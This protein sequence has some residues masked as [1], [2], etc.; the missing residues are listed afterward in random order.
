MAIIMGELF[1]F[2]IDVTLFRNGNFENERMGALE[3]TDLSKVPDDVLIRL[4]Q[5]SQALKLSKLS[6][7]ELIGL[8]NE[9]RAR[10]APAESGDELIASRAGDTRAKMRTEDISTAYDFAQARA[11]ETKAKIGDGGRGVAD[12]IAPGRRSEEQVSYDNARAEQKAMAEAYVQR[13]RADNPSM[14]ITDRTRTIGRGVPLAGPAGDEVNAFL[15]APLS[16]MGLSDSGQAYE[17]VLDYTRARNR[18]FDK[19]HPMESLGLQVGGGVTAGILAGPSILGGLSNLSR[20]AAVVTGAGLGSVTG[21]LDAFLNGEG[22]AAE[23]LQ[24]VPLGAG[25]GGLIGGAAPVAAEVIA[26]GVGRVVSHGAVRKALDGVGITRP[27][28]DVLS[29]ALEADGTIGAPGAA[30][31]AAAG[32]AG[33]VADAGPNARALLDTVIQRG[34]A[35]ATDARAAIEGRAADATRGINS[36]LDASLGRPIG[37]ETGEAAIRQGTASARSAAYRDAYAQPIDYAHPVGREIESLLS[38]VPGNAFQEA[39]RLMQVRG[40][41]SRQIL[42]RVADDGSI[43]LER[44]PDVRQ[45]DYITRALNEVADAADGM[46]KLG[47]QTAYG[48]AVRE[49]SGEIRDRLRQLVPEYN[50]ALQTAAEP[51][52]ARNALRFGEDYLSPSVARDEAARAVAR[53]THP[54][55]EALRQGIRS[56]I[57]EKL[58]NVRAVA[59]D[60]RVDARQGLDAIK[61]LSSDA[62]RYKMRLAL[63]SREA[64]ELFRQVDEFARAFELRAAVARNSATFARTSLDQKVKDISEPGSLGLIL[65]GRPVSAS[66][67]LVQTVLGTGPERQLARQDE[68]YSELARV[69]TNPRG[70]RA[71]QFTRDL[72]DA[73][74][75]QGRGAELGDILSKLMIGGAAGGVYRGVE[76]SLTRPQH[77]LRM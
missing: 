63:G 40:E 47:G 58:A 52:Q 36:A 46:G 55:R 30:N 31:I 73:L 44:L 68:I 74:R 14:A 12:L 64:D 45:L 29:R 16:A 75:A 25:L 77:H 50:R 76:Q 5:Q 6:D 11:N 61:A 34:G 15:N 19:A 22:G 54:E 3:V 70:A 48:N 41:R 62:V 69:L 32:P 10:G 42:A 21:G 23:R 7:T 24:D 28:A 2:Y 56:T 17:K 65:Q 67:R 20:P 71:V 60:P 35:G 66:R 27:T 1:D 33:M 4:Y 38:R 57:D 59:T 49:L 9:R 51:I 18:T 72:G 53:M 26:N 13:E 8:Y 39:N 37:I 43:A